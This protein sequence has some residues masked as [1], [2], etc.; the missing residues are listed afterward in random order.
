MRPWCPRAGRGTPRRFGE[1]PPFFSSAESVGPRGTGGTA[2][3]GPFPPVPK[4]DR[5]SRARGA[6]AGPEIDTSQ[7]EG[8]TRLSGSSPIESPGAVAALD[9]RLTAALG[10]VAARTLA[11]A[12]EAF[13][14]ALGPPIAGRLVHLPSIRGLLWALERLDR[15]CSF[16]GKPQPGAGLDTLLG[17]LEGT[18]ERVAWGELQRPR[19]LGYFVPGLKKAAREHKH[20]QAP[21]RKDR[22]IREGRRAPRRAAA[23]PGRCPALG[24][25]PRK[26]R[27]RRNPG[28]GQ[29]RGQ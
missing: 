2:P 7:P 3:K 9:R 28:Q 23:K 16:N 1:P 12:E 29:G 26:R 15:Y 22:R 27:R 8:S 20:E 10:V 19:H 21:V 4:E 6:P 5:Y 13:C 17:Q 11:A 24:Y 18:A 25:D 14:D